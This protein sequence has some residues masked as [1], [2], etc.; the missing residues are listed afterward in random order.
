MIKSKKQITMHK[1]IEVLKEFPQ[2]ATTSQLAD[3]V[4]C[5]AKT[6]QNYYKELKFDDMSLNYINDVKMIRISHGVYIIEDYRLDLE[7]AALEMEKKIF[8]KLALDNLE[9]LTDLSRHYGEIEEEL[10][11]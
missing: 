6:I 3:R 2:G 9:N 4:D 8:L 7:T 5:V 1:L 11:T 10:K